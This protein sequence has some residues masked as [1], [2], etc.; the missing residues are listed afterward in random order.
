MH[1]ASSTVV[2]SQVYTAGGNSGATYNADYVELFN[3]SNSPVNISGWALQYFSAAASATSNPV[4]SPVQGTVILQPGQRY[5]VQATPGTNGVAL[6]NAADQTSSNLAMGATA[7]RIYVTNSTTALSNASGCP[8]NYVDFVGYGT[9]ANCYEAARATA[10]SLSQPISRTNACVDGD[11]NATDFALT[12]TPARNSSAAPTSCS[13][14]GTILSNAAFNPSSVNA[15]QSS[16]LT[17]SGTRGLSVVADLSALVGSTTQML[18]DDGSNGDVTANDGIYS[19]TVAVPSSEAANT[20]QVTVRGTN[21]GM[22]SGTATATLTV[23]APV[24]F[25][26]IHTIQGST[27]GTSPYSGQVVMTHGIVTSVISNGYFIQARDSEADSDSHT[28]EG[29]LVYTG[30]GQVPTGAVVGNEVQVS[31]TVTLY[32]STAAFP[33]AELNKP[34][35]FSVLTT[36]N[37]LPSAVT[38]SST[39][40]SPSGGVQ[41][42]LYLQGMRVTAPSIT[43]T[44]PTDGNLTET[45]ET[46]TSNGQFWGEIS[47]LPRPTREPGL[48]VRDAF[49]ASQPLS[50]PRFDDD[51]ETFLIDSLA[52][53]NAAGV[54]NVTTGTVLNNVTGVIDVTDY[55]GNPGLILDAANRP[56]VAS[57]GMTIV[58]APA[59]TAGQISIG[60]QNMERFYNATADTA[61]AVTVTPAAYQLRLSKASLGIRNVLNSPDILALEE[62]ENLQTLTDLSNKISADAV[63]AG[64][65]DPQYQPYLVQ[66]NDPSG[67][68]VAFLVKPSKIDVVS[69]DQFGKSTQYTTPTGSQAILNDRPPLVLHA[70]VK[71]GSGA[72]DYPVTVIVNHLRSLNSITDSATGATVRAK[73]EAQAEYLANLVQG[74]QANG[75]HVIVVGDFNAFDVNDGLVDSMGV[76]RGNPAPASQ[77]VV[78]GA[79]GLVNPVLVDA[80]PTNVS[81]GA[82]SYVFNG[83]AQSIDHF[84]V[85]QDIA[86]SITTQPAH[87]NA[88]FPVIFRNDASRPEASSDHDGIVGYLSVP[89][90]QAKATVTTALSKQTDGSYLMAVTVTN[91]GS[92]TAQSVQVTGAVLGTTNTNSALPLQFGDI[93][94]GGSQTMT[95]SFPA[96]AGT[97]GSRSSETIRGTYSTGSFTLAQRLVLP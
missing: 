36:S 13:T 54:L 55:S 2:I 61:G 33:G 65:A 66:G 17:V 68:N 86:G 47:G 69:V 78:A 77:D 73:R 79:T 92:A 7:G 18:Y 4:I 49:T 6:T 43:V 46:Y 10:P 27:P 81:S 9:T 85:T 57:N 37:T 26:P 67:I 29:I 72:A 45:A 3:L 93:P 34:T 89:A 60:D 24:A 87:W 11:N 53:S 44:Q 14:G 80:A 96:S 90:A 59:A 76:I 30:S 31:G 8:T 63:A 41:Q 19:Y 52:G 22:M 88:D 21:S 58:P 42:L 5:L 39:L 1:A 38:L 82:Y 35:G 23:T 94:A 71:R 97:S 51:P 83:Y 75:E 16:L 70:G 15:G 91:S 50:I 48:E 64:Q 25:V 84:L 95:I 12:S 56:T 28:P 74:Y 20:Y 32:P 62:M 40:P